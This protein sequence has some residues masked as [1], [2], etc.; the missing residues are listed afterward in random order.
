GCAV[1][2]GW[3]P[4]NPR[5][6]GRLRQGYPGFEIRIVDEHD[7]EVA[8][9]TVGEFTARSSVPWT[10]STGYYNNPEATATAWRNGWL[11]TGDAF[12]RDKNGDYI[13]VDRLKDAI[14]RR[15]ENISSY[16]VETDVLRN[17]EIAECAA[18]AAKDSMGDEEILLF[19]VPRAGSAIT[20]AALWS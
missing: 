18:V 6:V 12:F 19:A 15:G 14:R 8:D 4:D 2:S 7:R 5:T 1:A 3:N 10:M 11:H 13:F 9:E 20:P 16:E 17:T